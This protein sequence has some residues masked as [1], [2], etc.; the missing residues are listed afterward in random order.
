MNSFSKDYDEDEDGFNGN[1]EAYLISTKKENLFNW[2]QKETPQAEE[3]YKSIQKLT[4]EILII[5]N[6]NVD[7][8]FQGQGFG[9]Q[10]LCELINDSYAN[11]AILVCDI[12]ETQ[13]EGFILE[14]FYESHDFKTIATNNDYPLMVYPKE[15]A[16]AIVSDLNT[17]LKI[18]HKP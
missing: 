5:K 17:S 10:I 15:I 6:L 8:E 4:G 13:K 16:E 7:E 2:L 11:A 12:G 18:K 3:I 14:K 9:T 1:C